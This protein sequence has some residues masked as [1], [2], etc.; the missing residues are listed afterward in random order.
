MWLIE[1]GP[2]N[3]ATLDIDLYMYMSVTT[4]PRSA[5]L[6]SS[7]QPNVEG[8]LLLSCMN[9]FDL[10]QAKRFK[11]INLFRQITVLR[12]PTVGIAIYKRQK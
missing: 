9:I 2:F 6:S 4:Y 12:N 8:G 10:H 3:S 5:V 7:S 1:S 11:S